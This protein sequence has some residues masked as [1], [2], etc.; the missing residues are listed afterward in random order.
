MFSYFTKIAAVAAVAIPMVFSAPT[1]HH[2]KIRNPLAEDVVA[3]SYIVVYNSDVTS[4][5]IT[6]H[7]SSITSLIAKRDT[8]LANAG[9]AATYDL[10][11]FK[12]YNVVATAETIASIA[13][14]PEVC[15]H[16]IL[17][18]HHLNERRLHTLKKMPKSMPQL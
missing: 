1:T 9:V 5:A 13:A 16:M 10:N 15:N 3:N 14:A 8:T 17:I 2:H 7:I 12:G 6:S 18:S 11:D 4:A